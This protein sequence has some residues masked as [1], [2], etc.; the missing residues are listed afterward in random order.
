MPPHLR[1]SLLRPTPLKVI[2][3]TGFIGGISYIHVAR[4]QSRLQPAT[5]NETGDP[6]IGPGMDH[7]K[8]HKEPLFNLDRI[9]K[10]VASRFNA[11]SPPNGILWNLGSTVVVSTVG[12][13]SKLFLK[14]FAPTKVFNKEPFQE[15]LDDETRDRPIITGKLGWDENEL[16]IAHRH[17]T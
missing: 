8:T 15:L 11:D 12:I 7:P 5:I 13:T 3:V 1:C 6:L 4:K 2:G 9:P 10:F 17:T 16:V 14:A